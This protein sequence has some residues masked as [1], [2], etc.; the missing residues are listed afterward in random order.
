MFLFKLTARQ[1][2]GQTSVQ[3]FGRKSRQSFGK[4]RLKTSNG[5]NNYLKTTTLRINSNGI[6]TTRSISSITPRKISR[7]I[8]GKIPSK[9]KTKTSSKVKSMKRSKST[10]SRVPRRQTTEEL[11]IKTSLTRIRLSLRPSLTQETR[12]IS[13]QSPCKTSSRKIPSSKK[14][15]SRALTSSLTSQPTAPPKLIKRKS[16][17]KTSNETRPRL[18]PPSRLKTLKCN[19]TPTSSLTPSSQT[20]ILTS[21]PKTPS[22]GSLAT[23]TLSRSSQTLVIPTSKSSLTPTTAPL[24]KLRKT[25]VFLLTSLIIIQ[26]IDSRESVYIPQLDIGSV[27]DEPLN[28]SEQLS[29]YKIKCQ[30]QYKE[31][32]WETIQNHNYDLSTESVRR[33]VC[34]GVWRARNCVAKSALEISSCGPLIAQ[35]LM[36]LP[37]DIEI[38]QEILDMCTEYDDEAPS[39]SGTITSYQNAMT[40]LVFAIILILI[41]VVA[42]KF[43]N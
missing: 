24:I 5:L 10:L 14:Q 19:Q 2:I 12:Q 38:R 37:N 35:E 22:T 36:S 33:S 30:N 1:K 15:T 32:V 11:I 6:T 39:C 41:S 8:S 42:F 27:E 17:I 18:T 3:R 40:I 31:L 25:I 4:T 43:C 29:P 13:R 21:T 28:C 16:T 26:Q 7:K 34:C 9:E 23:Q 20:T